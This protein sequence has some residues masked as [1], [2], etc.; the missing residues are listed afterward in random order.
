PTSA[1][2]GASRFRQLPVLLGDIN[3]GTEVVPPVRRIPGADI[4]GP[5][6]I[7]RPVRQRF[8]RIRQRQRQLVMP[9]TH[10]A[11]QLQ[12]GVY[13]GGGAGGPPARIGGQRQSVGVVAVGQHQLRRPLLERRGEAVVAYLQIHLQP[14]TCDN[15][16]R[17]SAAGEGESVAQPL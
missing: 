12:V 13:V 4:G 2:S 6:R 7:I 5:D 11:G 14:S 3:R 8:R 16:V 1:R 17:E 15:L 9:R 10:N